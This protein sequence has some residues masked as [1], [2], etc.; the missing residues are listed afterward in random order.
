VDD[1][2]WHAFRL[3]YA[4]VAAMTNIARQYEKSEQ[5]QD[6]EG[7]RILVA[8]D[9]VLQQAL[10]SLLLKRMGHTVATVGDGFEAV[11]AVQVHDYDVIMMDC[12]MPLMNGIDARASFAR[13]IALRSESER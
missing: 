8:E 11:S 2:F 13:F 12:H 3:R 9:S 10:V 7:L 1:T 6:Q 4:N 5:R